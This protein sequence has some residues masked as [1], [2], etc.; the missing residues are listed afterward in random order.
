VPSIDNYQGRVT[1]KNGMIKT[2]LQVFLFVVSFTI[3][4]GDKFPFDKVHKIL[5]DALPTASSPLSTLSER[6]FIISKNYY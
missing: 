4:F 5:I 3:D 1:N 6:I 2:F